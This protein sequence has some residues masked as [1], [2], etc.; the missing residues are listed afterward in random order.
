MDI[1]YYR[2][3][4]PFFGTWYFDGGKSMI[5][6]GSFASVF[7]ITRHDANV[8]PCALKIITIPESDDDI[9]S[10]RSEGMDDLNIQKYYQNMVDDI[11]REYEL[12]SGLKGCSTIVSCEDFMAYR[13]EDGFGFDIMI[14]M[15][16]LT[17][18]ISF[19]Q[20]NE[21][22]E[23]T[24]IKLGIDMCSALERCSIKN[25]IHRD[26]KP[27]NIFISSMGDFKLGDFGIARTM[28]N[29]GM[30]MSRKG[31]PNYMAPEVYFSWPYDNTAD[32][33]SLGIVLYGMLNYNRVPFL[34]PAPGAIS[35][36]DRENA[37]RRRI[38]GEPLPRPACGDEALKS[39]VLKACAYNK[40]ERYQ[41]P[42]E[43]RRHLE[44][45]RDIL[46]QGESVP[47]EFAAGLDATVA[48]S[49]NGIMDGMQQA[50]RD[51][52]PA[53]GDTGRDVGNHF[54]SVKKL[55]YALCGVAA[56]AV[57]AISVFILKGRMQA[58]NSNNTGSAST[59]KVQELHTEKP[60]ST[61]RPEETPVDK[62]LDITRLDA[63]KDG[64]TDMG[65]LVYYK[66]LKVLSLK[67]SGLKDTKGLS[68]LDG[69]VSLDLSN[70]SSLKDLS[71]ISGMES[72]TG[73]DISQTAVNSLSAARDL[74]LLESLDI[75]YTLIEDISPVKGCTG[76]KSLY[77][78]YNNENFTDKKIMSV[79]GSFNN[80]KELDLTGDVIAA[81]GL[82]KL[83]GLKGLVV[84]KIG[85]ISVDNKGL[86]PLAGL[87][88]LEILDLQSNI[89][90]TDFNFIK[91]FTKLKELNM[92]ATG[93]TDIKGIEKLKNLEKL[94]LSL[95]FTEDISMLASLKKLKEV[96]LT[97]SSS[98]NQQVKK[99]RK[100]LP[101]CEFEIQ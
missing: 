8:N 20:E 17:P 74:K 88:S 54:K 59:A 68:G 28:D 76:L 10:H 60:E 83:K 18:L 22:D 79:I 85:G 37:F 21:I 11:R 82:D 50:A 93:I 81:G 63:K 58:G 31:T 52:M 25:I 35:I 23:M 66:N 36:E 43:M 16:L 64:L 80:L 4:E 1:N 51:G 78:A 57:M 33:Y 77:A 48:A 12:M 41:H 49:N 53:D 90:I 14:R 97:G 96:T 42:E 98:I 55:V 39:I 84:L 45:V 75:S 65:E 100:A 91:G 70:N 46:V 15:E 6:S 9:A 7:R 32:I 30:M 62:R 19:G 101:G 87:K 69:L 92:S 24:V 26:I 94:D 27:A 61:Q 47:G 89:N 95:T 99:L 3:Y 13:H 86:K 67:N 40:A 38:K 5:G 73:L 72:L 34:P 71:G 29:Q 44:M 2:K 56:V